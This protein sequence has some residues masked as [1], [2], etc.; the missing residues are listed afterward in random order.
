MEYSPGYRDFDDFLMSLSQEKRKKIRQERRKVAEAGITFRWSLGKD[1]SNTDWDFF[2]RCY[3][4][5][6]YEHGNAPT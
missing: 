3:E 5:T 1:I 6:Y 4:R 2:Y